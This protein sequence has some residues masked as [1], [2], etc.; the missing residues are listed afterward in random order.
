MFTYYRSAHVR[1]RDVQSSTPN[2]SRDQNFGLSLG[3]EALASVW[4]QQNACR[5]KKTNKLFDYLY[6]VVKLD[7]APEQLHRYNLSHKQWIVSTI[8]PQLGLYDRYSQSLVVSSACRWVLLQSRGRLLPERGSSCRHE[9]Q[10][11][12]TLFFS[13]WCFESGTLSLTFDFLQTLQRVG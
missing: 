4:R 10:I 8:R 6:L 5:N 3:L 13:L 1:N 12:L 2:C 7:A 11:C 9:E